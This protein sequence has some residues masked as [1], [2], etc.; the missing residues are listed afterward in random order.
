MTPIDAV[1][2]GSVLRPAEPL[3]L[4]PNTHVRII[5]EVIPPAA[6]PG[7]SFIAVASSLDLK[8]PPDWASNL[9]EYLYGQSVEH[10]K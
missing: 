4:E 2:D 6:Q 1:Y 9:E 5:L 7:V 3:N 10:G 8:G